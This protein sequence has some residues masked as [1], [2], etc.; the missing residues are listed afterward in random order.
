[1]VKPLCQ[2][3]DSLAALD[4]LL[5]RGLHHLLFEF[6]VELRL[7]RVA[8]AHHRLHVRFACVEVVE[9]LPAVEPTEAQLNGGGEC[10][11]ELALQVRV[12]G[13]T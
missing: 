5:L 9:V 10:V 11:E 6:L 13:D 1:M 7:E 12:A 2:P 3:V 8:L 4:L